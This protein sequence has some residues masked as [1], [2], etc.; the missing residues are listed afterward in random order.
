MLL[1]LG[2]VWTGPGGDEGME[3]WWEARLTRPMTMG[4]RSTGLDW[5]GG[6]AWIGWAAAGRRADR[7]ADGWRGRS[8]SPALPTG[9]SRDGSLA[10][11]GGE[12]SDTDAVAVKCARPWRK[13]RRVCWFFG[14][15]PSLSLWSRRP[16][17]ARSLSLSF[18]P[19]SLSH[20]LVATAPTGV[21]NG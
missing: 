12:A 10:A 19:L 5:P 18:L 13:P 7:R 8:A 6:V 9:P 14:A 4:G 11:N 20:S 15:A 17:S 16:P 3:G 2:V 1:M 21:P